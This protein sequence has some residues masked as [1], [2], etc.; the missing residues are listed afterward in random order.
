MLYNGTGEV[1]YNGT[2]EVLYNGTGEVLYNESF[3]CHTLQVTG[4]KRKAHVKNS[5]FDFKIKR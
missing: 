3:R 4:K 2:G 5:V 1:P